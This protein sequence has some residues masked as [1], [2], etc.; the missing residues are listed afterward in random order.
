VIDEALLDVV[1]DA[2]HIEGAQIGSE[3]VEAMWATLGVV[4]DD[5]LDEFVYSV[6]SLSRS[7]GGTTDAAL[8]FRLG[9]WKLDLA[10]EGIR[11]GVLSAF[12]AAALAL[13]GLGPTDI[14]I[15]LATIV[16]P[17]VLSLERVEVG[18]KDERLLL[19]LRLRPEVQQ[20]FMTEDQLYDSL[21]AEARDVV[22]R[23]DFAEFVQRIREA[24]IAQEAG[25]FIRVR[26]EGERRPLISWS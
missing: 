18:A 17:S 5:L 16:L 4:D 22:N 20:R 23:F 13:D 26:Q 2:A 1:L 6:A 14:G 24:G 11:G 10:K 12:V 3:E 19:H 7:L 8:G 21:P 9:R 15:G 25:G